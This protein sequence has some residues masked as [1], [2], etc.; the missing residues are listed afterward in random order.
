VHRR[1]ADA[2]NA[3]AKVR[4]AFLAVITRMPH[5]DE[6]ALWER[7]FRERPRDAAADLVWVL[8]NSHEFRF[9]P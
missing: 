5:E 6:R 9:C 1:I 4:I 3:E 2:S 8:V 7:E